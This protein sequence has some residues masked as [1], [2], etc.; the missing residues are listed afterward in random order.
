M[1]I[2]F[3]QTQTKLDMSTDLH[4]NIIKFDFGFNDSNRLG[5]I[6][7]TVKEQ[8]VLPELSQLIENDKSR[9]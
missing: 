7:D 5:D 2:L 1:V 3:G 4:S 8:G 9:A 6:R